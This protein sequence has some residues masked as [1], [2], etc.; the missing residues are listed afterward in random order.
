MIEEQT[1]KILI[2]DDEPD[3]GRII[4]SWL[5]MA[6]YGCVTATT[7]EQALEL[8]Q[9]QSFQLVVSDIMMPGMSGID[10]LTFIKDLF[11]EVAVIL[12]TGVDDRK[13]AIM[14]LELGAYGYVIKPFDRNEI[15]INVANALERRRLTLMSREYE[16]SLESEVREKTREIREREEEIVLRLISASGFRDDET[17][18]HIRRIGL[19]AS[20]IAKDIGWNQDS[21]SDIRL[22]AAMHD[23]GKIGIPDSILLKPGK[24]TSE[25][26]EVM[27]KHTTIGAQLLGSSNIPLLHM[28]KEIA[29]S[30]HE[31]WDG[32]GYPDG[33]VGEAIPDSGR[34]VAL[35]DVYDALVMDRVY[36][37]AFPEP[38]ALA[39]M[40]SN[41][42]TYFDPRMFDR[43]M[44]LLPEI[45]R[46]RLEVQDED[47]AQP[48]LA[49]YGVSDMS[50]R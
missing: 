10:L 29:L 18:A 33:L 28:A 11:P 46:I 23:V 44:D 22:A 12:V 6:G 7:G 21:V 19:Y 24:L 30:H 5:S 31:K 16:Q 49:K 37:P 1:A 9:S 14:T 4:S 39:M 35:A 8:L 15:L 43:F 3:I 40:T 50:S 41:K 25:E 34:I 26:F 27:K 17:G 42:G 38:E 32:S 48:D 13:T 36:R 20:V 2:V 45:R 47:S